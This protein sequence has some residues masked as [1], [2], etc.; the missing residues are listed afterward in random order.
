M[1]IQQKVQFKL[2]QNVKLTNVKFYYGGSNRGAT[3][4]LS[5]DLDHLNKSNSF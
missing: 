3:A 1:D 4:R 5:L 2:D